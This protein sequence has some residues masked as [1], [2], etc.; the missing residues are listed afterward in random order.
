[1][2]SKA[3]G[4]GVPPVD[5]ALRDYILLIT[6]LVTFFDG[7]AQQLSAQSPAVVMGFAGIHSL[8]SEPDEP[9]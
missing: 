2:F 6:I 4:G 1:M 7:V 8:R 9:A 3:G 5:P